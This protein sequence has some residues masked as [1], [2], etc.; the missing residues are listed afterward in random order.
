MRNH[1]RLVAAASLFVLTAAAASAQFGI[2]A[3]YSNSTTDVTYSGSNVIDKL[4]NHGLYVGFDYD[5][6]I[7]AGFSVQPAVYYSYV[8]REDENLTDQ[9]LGLK[10]ERDYIEHSLMVPVHA[11]YTFEILPDILNVY[12]FAGPSFAI[13]LSALEKAEYD[14]R[15]IDGSVT[16]NY[17]TGEVY[18]EGLG[19]AVTDKWSGKGKTMQRFDVL[20]GGG[21]GLRL[22]RFLDIKAGYDYGLIDRT[23]KAYKDSMSMR[24]SQ[25][26]VGLGVRF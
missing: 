5:I 26:Y 24:R 23:A 7:V 12:L 4:N 10:Y 16:Y 17:Y 25:F 6:N 11:K 3:G 9:I 22:V 20:A 14:G 1:F 21:I 19:S 18:S 2:H 8:A 13:G 15:R